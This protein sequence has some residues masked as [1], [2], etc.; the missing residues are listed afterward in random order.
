[1]SQ[2]Y[3]NTKSLPTFSTKGGLFNFFLNFK[4]IDMVECKASQKIVTRSIQ[5]TSI[6]NRRQIVHNHLKNMSCERRN[7]AFKK[8]N[9][10]L[11]VLA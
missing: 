2:L 10:N 3:L 6:H 1:M 9:N 11:Y 5:H 4:L 8:S 7:P